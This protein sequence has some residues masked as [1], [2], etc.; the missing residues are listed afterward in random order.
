MKKISLLLTFFILASV[1]VDAQIFDPRKTAKRKAE[2]RANQK[3]DQTIDKALDKVFSGFG[4]KSKPKSEDTSVSNTE[5]NTGSNQEEDVSEAM[6]NLFGKL[7][8]GSANPPSGSYSFNSSYTMRMK[9]QGRKKDDNYTMEMKYMFNEGGKVMGAKMLSTDNPEMSKQVEMMEA[10]VFDWGKN[11]VYSFMNMN[12]QKQYIGVSVKDGGLGDAMEGQY[13]KTTFTN[14]GKTKTIAGYVCDA[15]LSSD[16]KDEYTVWISQKAIPSVARYYDSF[17][18]MSANQQNQMKMAYQANPEMM[19]MMKEGRAMLG[20][21][22]NDNATTMEMEV[23][24]I[25]P[26]DNYTFN[27]DGYTSMMDM[28]AIMKQAEQAEKN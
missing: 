22:M 2:Q 7:G 6:S 1:I 9:S 19:K 28:G 25:S 23:V 8:M 5:S 13:E 17:N 15:Y 18:K 12:G 21:E 4:K 11:Q 20:M 26:N 10:I 14:L 24:K 27:A 3:I 16:G